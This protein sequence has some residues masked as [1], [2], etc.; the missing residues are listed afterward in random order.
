MVLK[1]GRSA[2]PQVECRRWWKAPVGIIVCEA[3]D[4]V[5]FIA[6][7][8]LHDKIVSII[9]N[10]YNGLDLRK[11]INFFYVKVL[12]TSRIYNVNKC[13]YSQ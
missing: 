11:H 12:M 2:R 1:G 3:A 4:R 5:L 9:A 6:L 7:Y 13:M 10:L 8:P